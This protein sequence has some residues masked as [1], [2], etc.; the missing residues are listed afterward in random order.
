[1]SIPVKLASEIASEN[2]SVI[3][4]KVGSWLI[5]NIG[6]YVLFFL[7]TYFSIFIIL[8]SEN[9]FMIDFDSS[10]TSSRMF[11]ARRM[12]KGSPSTRI[13]INKAKSEEMAGRILGIADFLIT[14]IAPIKKGQSLIGLSEFSQW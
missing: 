14:G 7:N 6:G 11:L 1:M 5:L 3:N 2:S 10:K 4:V 9:L 8:P 12:T 13:S